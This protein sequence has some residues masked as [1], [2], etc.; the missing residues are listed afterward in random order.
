MKDNNDLGN[1]LAFI[2]GFLS[3]RKRREKKEEMENNNKFGVAD[4][5][6]KLSVLLKEGAITQSEFDKQKSKLLG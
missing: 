3:A 6:Q 1:S 5:L 2:T 4:E